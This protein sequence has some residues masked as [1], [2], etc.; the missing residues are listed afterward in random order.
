DAEQALK[1]YDWPGNIRELVNVLNRAVIL[2]K[3]SQI[4]SI[5]LGLFPEQAGS[6]GQAAPASERS[7]DTWLSGLVDLALADHVEDLPPIGLWLEEDLIRACLSLND[8]VLNRAAS[9]L[10]IPE[11]TLRR[12]V[13][14]MRDEYGNLPP[15][16]PTHWV[17]VNELLDNLI[18]QARRERIPLL[19]YISRLL[20]RELEDRHINRK[21]AATLMGVSVPTYRRLISVSP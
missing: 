18:E 11:S 10:N 3:D 5:H 1:Q 6:P 8:D 21:E 14:R 16:R 20:I 19:D 13:T 4:S 2:C 7:P 12:K 17:P 15:P 9:T